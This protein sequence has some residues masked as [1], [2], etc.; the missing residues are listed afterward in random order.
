MFEQADF[1]N[2]FKSS[3]KKATHK[4]SL[5]IEKTREQSSSSEQVPSET[6]FKVYK[7]TSE[8]IT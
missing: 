4:Q 6:A 8:R 2:S 7:N 5:K 1:R 3:V